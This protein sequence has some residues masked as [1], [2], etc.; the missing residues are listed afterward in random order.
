MNRTEPNSTIVHIAPGA[1]MV[2]TRAF[3]QVSTARRIALAATPTP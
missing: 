2:G 1:R 3:A